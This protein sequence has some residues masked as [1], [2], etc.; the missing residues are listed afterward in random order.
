MPDD[1]G[2][3]ITMEADEAPDRPAAGATRDVTTHDDGEEITIEAGSEQSGP[4]VASYGEDETPAGEAAPPQRRRPA[5]PDP[6][7]LAARAGEVDLR[8][9]NRSRD[10]LGAEH[11]DRRIAR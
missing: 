11:R 10:R 2:P 5:D 3:V 6:P 4:M 8:V 7:E 1:S 9:W